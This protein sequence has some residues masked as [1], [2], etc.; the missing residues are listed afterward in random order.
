MKKLLFIFSFSVSVCF[1]QNYTFQ[2][3]NEPYQDLVGST[4]L[5][6]GLIWDEPEITFNPG[7]SFQMGTQNFSTFFVFQDIICNQ[8]PD[9][10]SGLFS[11]LTAF[12]TDLIDRAYDDNEGEAGGVS[13]ISYKIEGVSPNRILKL[14]WK[15]VGF[16][17]EKIINDT[18]N[19]FANFQV[20]LYETTHIIEYRYG[21]NSITNPEWA[22]IGETGAY[23]VVIPDYD[24]DSNTTSN[25]IAI[26]GNPSSPTVVNIVQIYDD[27]LNGTPS[28]GTVYRFTPETMSTNQ[29]ELSKINIYPNPTKDILYFDA[30]SGLDI[31]KVVITNSLGQ[32]VYFSN[33]FDNQINIA[34]L[35]SG[36]YHLTIET[37]QGKTNRKIIKK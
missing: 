7:F 4:S 8:N 36:V 30:P 25:G 27:F 14:E 1:A 32:E 29:N 35:S 6:N 18:T 3:L 12:N 21:P 22:Y 10:F 11:I 26:K 23:V 2:V 9:T 19:D 37:N 17:D 5:T 13:P 31:S 15:N 24:G 20:W 33:S 34:S 16:Y 28:N